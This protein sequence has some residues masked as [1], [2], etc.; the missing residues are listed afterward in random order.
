[1][2]LLICLCL[3][4]IC[5]LFCLFSLSV[6]R[7]LLLLFIFKTVIWLQD[8]F[9]QHS[10]DCPECNSPISFKSITSLSL[11][12]IPSTYVFVLKYTYMLLNITRCVHRMTFECLLSS[13]IIAYLTSNWCSFPERTASSAPALLHHLHFFVH[14]GGLMDFSLCRLT[15]SLCHPCCFTF[16]KSH[17]QAFH[18]QTFCY[19]QKN[20]LPNALQSR[21]LGKKVASPQQTLLQ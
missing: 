15:C 8:S 9:P 20:K 13:Q 2:I 12:V 11:F 17:C 4:E 19:K 10:A 1:M 5:L 16:G 3:Q 21:M 6:K 18:E 14:G 7:N